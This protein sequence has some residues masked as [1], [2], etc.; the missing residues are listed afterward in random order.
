MFSFV[1]VL[2]LVALVSVSA[3]SGK[4]IPGSEL[5]EGGLNATS[6]SSTCGGN[7]PGGC[8][9][10]PC[11]KLIHWLNSLQD[12]PYYILFVHKDAEIRASVIVLL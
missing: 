2:L 12:T 7:C 5:M 11:G 3:G 10:C 9:S 6:G 8:S 4:M 1:V